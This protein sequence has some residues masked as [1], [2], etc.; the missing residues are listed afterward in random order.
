MENYVRV[1]IGCLRFLESSRFLSS[2]LDKLV[3][4]INR[5]PIMEPNMFKDEF[6]K[7]K[8]PYPCEYFNFG[9]FQ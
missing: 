1:Q 5:F 6:L 4:S 2:S 3:R 8:F 7:K 9:N